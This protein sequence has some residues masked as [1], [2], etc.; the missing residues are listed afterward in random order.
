MFTTLFSVFIAGIL[1]IFPTIFNISNNLMF[2]AVL[3]AG[4]GT[5]MWALTS[6]IRTL[7]LIP[8]RSQT[9]SSRTIEFF[10]KDS[11]TTVRDWFLFFFGFLSYVFAIYL[12]YAD[13]PFKIEVFALWIILLGLAIDFTRENN[14]RAIKFLDPFHF[15]TILQD[16]A[17]YAIQ[18]DNNEL[19]WTAMDDLAEVALN[20]IEHEKM[21][22]TLAA[23]NGVE[24][25][26]KLFFSSSKSVGRLNEGTTNE[27][28]GK[29][30]TQYTLFYQLQRLQYLYERALQKRLEPI[31]SRI[32]VIFGK[33]IVASAELDLSLIPIPVN[34]I[35]KF[36]LRALQSNMDELALLASGTLIEV[37][38]TIISTVDLT[39]IELVEPF[40]SVIN[41]L[42]MIAKAT[43]KKDK[44]INIKMLIQPLQELKALFGIEKIAN[45]RDTPA[46][47]QN[48]DRVLAEYEA[49][50]Q[51]MRSIPAPKQG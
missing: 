35:G 3:M 29:D 40:Q 50:E 39:Y 23:L 38:K 49:L 9:S 51:V 11:L 13:L 26:L 24:P 22:V 15:I 7:F 12:I 6:L 41:S 42:D 14:G 47:V 4:V 37:S 32:I 18:Q 1:V 33:I 31:L 8:L 19:L 30:E 2:A 28:T 21:G 20:G 43:F 48:I 46:V 44:N 5:V 36:G 45:H 25:T 17:K 34:F 10:R 27:K 16:K